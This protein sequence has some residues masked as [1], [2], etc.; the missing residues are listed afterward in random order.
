MWKRSIYDI[1]RDFLTKQRAKGYEV[2]IPEKE[3][4]VY[5]LAALAYIYKRIKETEVISEAHHVVIDEAQ[6]FGMMAYCVLKYCIRECTYTIM[7]DVSQNIHFGYGLND[8]EEL[9]ELLL[10][11]PQDSFGVLKKSYR[12]TV[13]ISD[14]AT[15]ILHHG[16]FSSYPV[17]PIIRHGDP[18]KVSEV[19]DTGQMMKNAAKVC[20]DW[21]AKGFDTIAVVCRNREKAA[22]AARE[23]EK[24]IPIVESDL[25]KAEFSSGIMVLPVEYTKGL[26]FDA[27]LIL[28]PTR[29]EYPVDDGHA[30]LLYVAAT[31][32]LHELCVMHQGNLTGLIADPLPA[33]ENG[34]RRLPENKGQAPRKEPKDK[35]K[36]PAAA[37]TIPRKRISIVRNTGVEERGQENPGLVKGQ[38]RKPDLAEGRRGNPGLDEGQ[39]RVPARPVAASPGNRGNGSSSASVRSLPDTGRK[40]AADSRNNGSAAGSLRPPY[41]IPKA[42]VRPAGGKNTGKIEFG[43][44]PATEI[45]R[46]AGHSKIDL[47]VR[48]VNKRPDGLYLQSRYGMLRLSPVGSAIVR[49]TFAKGMQLI[50]GTNPN[51]AVQRI[52]KSWKYKEM[53][54][55]IELTTEELCLQVD[56]ATGAI[57]YLT[58]DKNLLLS[59]R[60][61]ECRQIETGPGAVN[62]AWLFLDWPK[63][64]VLYGLGAGD[65]PGIKLRGT[66][67]YISHDDGSELPLLLSDN[68]YGILVA[69]NKPVFCCDISVYGSYL[70]AENEQQLDYYFIG[71]K[72]QVTIM[73][74]YA[75]LC[76]RL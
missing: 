46:P 13:E 4:D 59:E 66:A 57:R 70:C 9:K 73:N 50:E 54:N 48:W 76:G 56:K 35:L 53:G 38:Q 30:K 67:R 23:L 7:G 21:Q 42:P 34:G 58:R 41:S 43:D 68:G 36:K 52:E 51:I 39:W 40:A 60:S 74:A 65:K 71:G 24:Y 28:D 45:L 27:V 15:N 11:E 2:A 12:N 16:R 17:E 22:A 5:D 75:Y 10:P 6:D 25:E 8:W 44:M 31:R 37:G 61:K 19:T 3:F 29:E 63:G 33:G 62:R 26:E 49:V 20:K 18:V 14:F 69:T 32:A 72:K 1:Y 64:E 55:I 47:A